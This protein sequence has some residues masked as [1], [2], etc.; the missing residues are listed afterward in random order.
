MLTSIFP[1][2]PLYVEEWARGSSMIP[3]LLPLYSRA[4]RGIKETEN[5][6]AGPIP[7]RYST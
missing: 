4:F 3:I 1:L 7:G 6:T 5:S 2:V